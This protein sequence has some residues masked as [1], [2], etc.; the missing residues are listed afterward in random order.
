MPRVYAKLCSIT[1][2]SHLLSHQRIHIYFL[3]AFLVKVLKNLTFIWSQKNDIPPNN[4]ALFGY[5]SKTKVGGS[6]LFATTF[7]LHELPTAHTPPSPVPSS[8][9]A[10][11]E[12]GTGSLFC[13]ITGRRATGSHSNVPSPT[14]GRVSNTQSQP[15]SEMDSLLEL[16]TSFLNL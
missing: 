7:P 2:P 6:Q 5:D 1:Q 12:T 15:C 14:I 16:L 11:T 8:Q 13:Y 10:V 3:K 9:T 4:L